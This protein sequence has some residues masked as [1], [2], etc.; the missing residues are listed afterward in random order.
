EA[1]REFREGIAQNEESL[2]RATAPRDRAYH[3]RGLIV[4]HNF[5]GNAF[6]DAG[7]HRQAR[8]EYERY[9]QYAEQVCELMPDDELD[10]SNLAV[11]DLKLAKVLRVERD[12]EAALRCCDRAVARLRPLVDPVK[13]NLR[14]AYQLLNGFAA[15]G[16]LQLR[17]GR[18]AELLR[19]LAS[20]EAVEQ[21]LRTAVE[22]QVDW[23]ETLLQLAEVRVVAMLAERDGG[24][25]AA[26]DA[27]AARARRLCE[28]DDDPAR[29]FDLAAAEAFAAAA[30]DEGDALARLE[31][32]I[33]AAGE[34]V[35]A[36]AARYREWLGGQ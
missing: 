14:R 6:F 16:R 5:L 7:D 12:L 8:A 22:D 35:P 13:P 31:R 25:A 34:R 28:L 19:D 24:A 10:Q 18:G 1:L 32:A 29:R 26:A 23:H 20:I 36:R 4:S 27:F 2:R 33:A 17:L 30:R 9:R 15:R 3:L 11:A 21:A